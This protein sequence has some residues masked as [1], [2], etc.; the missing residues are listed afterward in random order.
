MGQMSEHPSD[1]FS[2]QR[3]HRQ[4]GFAPS[5]SDSLLIPRQVLCQDIDL[6]SE[7]LPPRFLCFD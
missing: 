3:Q 5:E 2:V 6:L 1:L 4:E 7:K